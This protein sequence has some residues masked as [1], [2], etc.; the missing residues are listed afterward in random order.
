MIQYTDIKEAR[1]QLRLL[2][3]AF[4]NLQLRQ[5]HLRDYI[6]Q[7][8][9]ED[10]DIRTEV[11]DNRLML[12]KLQKKIQKLNGNIVKLDREMTMKDIE[13]QI[14]EDEERMNNLKQAEVYD[15]DGNKFYVSEE[16][17]ESLMRRIT[18]VANFINEKTK[19]R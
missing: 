11:C 19:K 16:Y 6:H 10:T 3:Y 2:Q 9:D 15:K 17:K 14:R 13:R 1:R 7:Y 5:E 12:G 8:G 18:K 4:R